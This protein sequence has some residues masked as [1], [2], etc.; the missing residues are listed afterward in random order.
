VE[1]FPVS[2]ESEGVLVQYPPARAL[3]QLVQE[4]GDAGSRHVARQ[5]LSEGVPWAFRLHPSLFEV[6][7]EWFAERMAVDPKDITLTGSARVGESLSP[8]SLGRSFGASSDLDWAVVSCQLFNVCAASFE[9][10]RGEL[11]DGEVRAPGQHQERLWR[12]NIGVCSANVRRGFVDPHK[13]PLLPRYRETQELMQT[14]WT[15]DKKLAATPEAPAVKRSTLRVY[16]SWESYVRQTS[17]NL[18]MIADRM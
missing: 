9:R 2:R 5:W 8:K 13:V 18:Q 10:W 17:M 3:V 7:R 16:K 4:R 6:V 14:L 12:E 1:P 15:L 11:E